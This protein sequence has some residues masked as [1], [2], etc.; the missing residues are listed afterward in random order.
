MQERMLSGR[1]AWVTGSSRGIG[2]AIAEHLARLGAAV[3][4]HGTSP[5]STR[6]FGEADS[7]Q[8]V[9]DAVAASTGSR[10]L[11]VHGDLTDAAVVTDLRAHIEDELGAIHVLVNCAGGD[12]GTAGVAAPMAGKPAGNNAIDI[13]LA[14]I[15]MVLDRNLMTVILV[16][17]EVAAG[18]RD[19]RQGSIVTIGSIAGLTG[20]DGSAI[21]ATAKAAAHEYTRCLATHLRPYNVRANVVAPGDIVTQRFVASRPIDEAMLVENDTLKRY[22]RPMEIARVVGFLASDEASYITGQVMRV[23]G[24]LQ[25]WPA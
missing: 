6:A 12:V 14:D 10:T 19:R 11:A 22:G 21:Y 1:V 15:R 9:A 18:M 13:A 4:V 16:S 20:L 17:R 23:D 5:T 24:G 2:R 7:L 25:S 8:A 3:A